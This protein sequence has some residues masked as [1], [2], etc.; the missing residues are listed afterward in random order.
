MKSILTDPTAVAALTWLAQMLLTPLVKKIPPTNVVWVF[1]RAIHGLFDKID[2]PTTGT[3][4]ALVAFGAMQLCQGCSLEAA[5]NRRVE[6]QL[7]AR[8]AM[9]AAAPA[10]SQSTDQQCKAWDSIHIWGDWSGGIAGGLG[11]TA[12]GLAL[13][14]EDKTRTALTTTGL[15]LG[16]A[17]TAAFV[18]ADQS[19]AS[20]AENCQ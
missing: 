18:F 8:G 10:R 11:A 20:W 3:V 19:A 14:T 13:A 7:K 2:P 1:I 9:M 4:L 12:T 5:R 17:S 6:S 15:V 16:A